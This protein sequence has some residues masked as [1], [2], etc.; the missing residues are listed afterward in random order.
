MYLV[1]DKGESQCQI[2]DQRIRRKRLKKTTEETNRNRT[3]DGRN[4][5]CREAL[6]RKADKPKA[7][8]KAAPKYIATHK[9]VAGDT[10]SGLALKYYGSAFVINWM[11]IYEANRN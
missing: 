2:L 7:Q 5:S 11:Q 8:V 9:V 1:I 3:G 10:M 6:S 4:E